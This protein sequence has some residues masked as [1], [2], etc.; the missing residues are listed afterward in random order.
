[1]AACSLQKQAAADH[2]QQVKAA[3]T[4]QQLQRHDWQLHRDMPRKH[5]LL[6][7]MLYETHGPLQV[8]EVL[9]GDAMDVTLTGAFATAFSVHI[10]QHAQQSGL[11][12]VFA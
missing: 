8:H 2:A 11:S 5:A 1:M 12:T 6:N 4:A 3:R 7:G 10:H 9:H